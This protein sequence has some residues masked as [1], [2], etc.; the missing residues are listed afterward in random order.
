MATISSCET[1]RHFSLRSQN[2]EYPRIFQIMGAN[3][4]VRK[5]L[6]TDLV[7]TN[8]YYCMQGNK[9]NYKGFGNTRLLIKKIIT[10]LCLCS[11]QLEQALSCCEEKNVQALTLAEFKTGVGAGYK[12]CEDLLT[13]LGFKLDDDMTFTEEVSLGLLHCCTGL[14]EALV[15]EFVLRCCAYK[16]YKHY[17]VLEMGKCAFH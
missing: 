3:Q 11:E 5:L 4:N 9:K 14:A 6:S 17:F 8:K 7:N 15:G 2:S 10:Y 12:S 16:V 1:T 13:L